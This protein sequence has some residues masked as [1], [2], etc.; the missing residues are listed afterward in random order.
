MELLYLIPGDGMP[1]DELKRR[2]ETGN[3]IIRPGSTFHTEEV[4][5][6]PLSRD[7]EAD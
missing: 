6:G 5:K 1:E 4:G 7:A 3:A 2:A